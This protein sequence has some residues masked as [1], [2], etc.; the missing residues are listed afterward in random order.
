V[1]GLLH[2]A[3][4]VAMDDEVL[5]LG[6]DDAHE[7]VRKQAEKQA[8]RTAEALGQLFGRTVRCEYVPTGRVGRP[9]R[10]AGA[11]VRLSSAEQRKVAM[12]PAVKAVTDFFDGSIT[13][14]QSC[15]IDLP[16]EGGDDD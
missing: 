6:Y 12:D 10:R 15:P 14:I 5:Q 9:L 1:S 3:R 13:D 7:G 16:D 4:V 2:P 8:G 11:G